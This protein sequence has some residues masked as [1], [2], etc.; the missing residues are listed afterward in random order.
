MHEGCPHGRLVDE[1]PPEAENTDNSFETFSDPHL[2][3]TTLVSLDDTNSSNCASQSGH[4]YSKS[5]I[6]FSY[7]TLIFVCDMTTPATTPRN[8]DG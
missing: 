6:D 7:I 4:L 3:Q 8:V 1:E 5:G 2:G